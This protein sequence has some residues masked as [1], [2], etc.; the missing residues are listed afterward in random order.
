MAPETREK[1]YRSWKKAGERTFNWVD[2]L[3]S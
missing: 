2:E 1:G 3:E